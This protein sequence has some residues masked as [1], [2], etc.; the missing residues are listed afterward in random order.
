MVN[1]CIL[2]ALRTRTK[3]RRTRQGAHLTALAGGVG[4]RSQVCS[5]AG[6]SE[7]GAEGRTGKMFKQSCRI[8]GRGRRRPGAL[9]TTSWHSRGAGRRMVAYYFLTCTLSNG[10]P[11]SSSVPPVLAALANFTSS[12]AALPT[13]ALSLGRCPAAQNPSCQIPREQH[14][15]IP[16]P[17]P[18]SPLPLRTVQTRSNSLPPSPGTPSLRPPSPMISSLTP[19]LP[20]PPGLLPM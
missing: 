7:S 8:C 17:P 16:T 11:V 19:F 1:K 6:A 3:A 2:R 12:P 5:A 18:L 20:R 10:P 13:L 15:P 4:G 14:R 9:E